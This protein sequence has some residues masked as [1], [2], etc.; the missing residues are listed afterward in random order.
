MA[1][2]GIDN[3]N[4][5]I[6]DQIDHDGDDNDDNDDEEEVNTTRPF[7]PGAASTPHHNGEQIE[8]HTLPHE[9][10]GLDDTTPLLTQTQRE[11]AW[12]TLK[13][14]YPDASYRS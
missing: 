14:L 8:M 9:H 4:P 7:Q 5:W 1:E 2:G 11:W 13:D 12:N 10:S 6:D 3:E